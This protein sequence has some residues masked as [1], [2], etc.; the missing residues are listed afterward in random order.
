MKKKR[1]LRTKKGTSCFGEGPFY[2]IYSAR[3][4]LDE[5]I[6]AKDKAKRCFVQPLV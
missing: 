5:E 2:C 6:E 4:H 3:N 1:M